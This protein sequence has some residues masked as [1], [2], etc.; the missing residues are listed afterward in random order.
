MNFQ[1]FGL[2]VLINIFS[3]NARRINNSGKRHKVKQILSN[4]NPDFTSLKETK[5]RDVSYQT[6]GQLF[7]HQNIGYAYTSAIDSV[8]WIICYGNCT[9]FIESGRYYHPRFL[10]IKDS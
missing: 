7:C 5:L 9:S 10:V 1:V 2:L 8:G 4:A 3:W 6:V